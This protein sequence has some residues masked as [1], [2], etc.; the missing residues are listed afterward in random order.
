VLSDLFVFECVCAYVTHFNEFYRELIVS[1]QV[2][3]CYEK[4]RNL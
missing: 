4:L 1:L 3:G 2:G